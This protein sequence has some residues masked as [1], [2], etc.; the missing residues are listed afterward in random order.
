MDGLTMKLGKRV[1]GAASCKLGRTVQVP[2]HMR[3]GIVEL[4]GLF[5]PAEQRREG[6]ATS[7]VDM[8]CNEADD[9][10]KVLLLHVAP[11]A[12]G[13]MSKEQLAAWYAGRFGFQPIQAEPLL[14]ARMV[15]A[16]PRTTLNPVA[17]A[18][19]LTN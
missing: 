7:L 16:T 3:D 19:Q 4:S 18:A 1:F 17:Q 2:A 15:G 11:Y 9:D 14:M 12:P 13:G 8:I 5:C 6:F 10:G